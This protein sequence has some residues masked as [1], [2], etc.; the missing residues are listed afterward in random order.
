MRNLL[1]DVRYAI[2]QFYKSPGFVVG[3]IVSLT[4]GIGAT[5]TVFSVVYGVLLSPFPYKDANRIV[6]VRVS[7]KS[8]GLSELRVNG[9]QFEAI[10]K[11]SSVEDVF[12]QKVESK[13]LTGEKYPIVLNAGF[14]S[15]NALD[16][17]GVP[18][19]VGRV[20]TQADTSD[21]SPAPV[22]VLSY[23]FWQEHYF[24][25]REVIGKTIQLDQV[26]YTVIGVMPPRFTWLDSDVYLLGA[27]TGDPDPFW[28]AFPKLKRGANHHAVEAEFQALVVALAKETLDSYPETPR[29]KVVSLYDD[30]LGS[31]GGTVANLFAAAVVLLIIACANVSI[32]LLARGTARQHELAVRTSLGAGRGRLIRQLLTESVLLSVTATTFG[33]LAAWWGVNVARKMLPYASVPSEVAVQLN[34]PVLLFSAVIA[35]V[36]GILFGL[37]PAL[38]LSRPHFGSVLQAGSM[39]V[40][41]SIRARRMHRLPIAGQV[42]LTLLLLA[43]ASAA[44]KAL[45]AK[46]HT[47]RGFDPDH[48]FSM[49]VHLPIKAMTKHGGL[50]EVRPEGIQEP[51]TEQETVRSAIAQAPGVAE[52][53]LSPNWFPGFFG[54]NNKI[55]IKSK[56]TLTDA[57]AVLAPISPQ[58][59]SVFR[60]PLL[61][62][63][64][65][66]GPEVQRQAHV[67]V[68][69]QA[70]LKQ[71]LGEVDPIGQRI[72]LPVLNRL[73]SSL[74][75]DGW[76]EVIG[77]VGDA[78]NDNLEHPRVRPAVFIPSSFGNLVPG[79]SIYVRASG[80]P[81]TT[82]RS[83]RARLRELD[84]DVVVVYARTL[85][86]DLSW[87]WARERL[88]ATILSLYGGV[89]L[90]LAATGLY[91]VVSF[92]VT[93]RTQELGI[94][95]A[96]GAGRGSI[97]RLVLSST[98]A[99]LGIGVLA[100]LILS[101]IVSPLVSTWGGGRLSQPLT[102]FG[103][104]LVLM[105]VATIACVL[106]AWRAASTDL[107]KVLRAE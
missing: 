64:I 50:E 28:M 17:L 55:E 36:T 53:G 32:L 49:P 6:Y 7:D 101:A 74:A 98:A 68:V 13:T 20:F 81:E 80:D 29:V 1:Q 44:A 14:Y 40:A 15:P 10:R 69:N 82:I 90:V 37:S 31:A 21:G 77:V 33:V 106:P 63:R 107:M 89:A 95:I 22:A 85:Q 99:M 48:V 23:R 54:F 78:T 42:A 18:A 56:P 9:S 100:G 84:P 71:Y 16:F 79:V 25:S 76:M 5:T 83:V 3:A 12:F 24:K 43:G 58:L 11:V 96:L 45:L 86:S 30:A 93:Q 52:A 38:E 34:L 66:D 51:I 65:F 105:L 97:A 91:S 70:F 92:A 41:G 27:P 102:L 61:R 46:M 62:G 19:L 87:E 103:A 59:L 60:I 35:L 67:A 88:L 39:R 73:H 2:R 104:A 75:A 94:R 8:G 72:R 4:L 47:L 57:E 26:P